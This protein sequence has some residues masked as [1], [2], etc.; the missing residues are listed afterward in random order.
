MPTMTPTEITTFLQAPRHAV[1]GTNT[2]NGPPQLSPVWYL[3]EDGH[4]Y[5]SIT[6]ETAKYRNLHHDPCL[7]LCIDG[8]HPDYRTVIVYGVAEFR[9]SN[10]PA[11]EEMRWRIIRRY[12]EDEAAA[13][14]YAET[15]R[16]Q[17][18]VLLVVTPTRLLSQDFN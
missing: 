6:T 3:Y 9:P 13:W 10:T 11:A 4:F 17:A 7:S 1:L 14:R 15:T 18:N 5:I 12:Y 8:G 2:R 16:D